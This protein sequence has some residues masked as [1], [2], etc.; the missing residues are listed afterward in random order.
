MYRSTSISYQ[1]TIQTVVNCV[2][3]LFASPI[4]GKIG[5]GNWYNLGAGLSAAT[6]VG[7]IFLCPETKYERSL[8]AYGQAAEVVSNDKQEVQTNQPRQIRLSARPALDYDRYKVRTLWSD[9]RLFAHR[10][11]WSEGLYAL[12]VRWKQKFPAIDR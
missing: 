5:P 12:R 3:C 4:A 2:Y 7:S 8:A 1:V 10:A 6:L 11:D 9:M